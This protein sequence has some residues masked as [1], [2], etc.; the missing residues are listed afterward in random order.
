MSIKTWF[1]TKQFQLS[2]QKEQTFIGVVLF[3]Q[4]TGCLQQC[5]QCMWENRHVA[6]GIDTTVAPIRLGWCS[7]WASTTTRPNLVQ[8]ENEFLLFLLVVVWKFF[9]IF[10]PKI[11]EDKPIFDKQI[12]S[13]GVETTSFWLEVETHGICYKCFCCWST[14]QLEFPMP[15]L[16]CFTPLARQS[17]NLMTSLVLRA[18]PLR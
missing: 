9:G 14:C 7:F 2:N 13:E 11:E 16:L 5:H 4:S 12:F 8:R 3:L 1:S 15:D 17:S 10:T 18:I 6:T